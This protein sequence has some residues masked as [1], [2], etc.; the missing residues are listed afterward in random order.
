MV[1]V[2]E[3]LKY[4]IFIILMSDLGSL[5]F[6]LPTEQRRIVRNLERTNIKLTNAKYAVAYSYQQKLED[7]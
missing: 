4:S 1:N 6:R 2:T 7:H 3:T 5:I